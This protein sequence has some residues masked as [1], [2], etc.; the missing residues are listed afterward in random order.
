LGKYVAEHNQLPCGRPAKRSLPEKHFPIARSQEY[1]RLDL[2]KAVTVAGR[3]KPNENGDYAKGST[4]LYL[5]GLLAR[6]AQIP[7]SR[8]TGAL[9]WVGTTDE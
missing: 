4:G 9:P 3:R 7:N 5:R 1:A 8:I 2:S 6:N